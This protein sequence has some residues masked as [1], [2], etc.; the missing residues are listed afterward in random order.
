MSN[1]LIIIMKTIQE[2]K[3]KAIEDNIAKAKKSG[4]KLTQN[5]DKEGNLYGVNN[6]I[7][8]SLKTKGDE[9]GRASCRERV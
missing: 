3:R 1:N 7:E 8:E 4:N 9:I 5:I 6:T 2:T